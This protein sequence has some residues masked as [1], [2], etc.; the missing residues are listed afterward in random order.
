MLPM[1]TQE[2]EDDKSSVY[3]EINQIEPGKDYEPQY[4]SEMLHDDI[5][6]QHEEK[7]F[8]N[9]E[10]NTIFFAP[11]AKL[12]D[13]AMMQYGLMQNNQDLSMRRNTEGAGGNNDTMIFA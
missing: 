13:Q 5:G 6:H 3:T 9:Q 2:A 11:K 7:M 4:I 8:K 1:S 10:D 12:N